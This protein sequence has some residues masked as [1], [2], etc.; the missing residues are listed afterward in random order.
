MSVKAMVEDQL[1]T[2]DVFSS[3]SQTS[4]VRSNFVIAAQ[5][6]H[7]STACLQIHAEEPA[8]QLENSAE[9]NTNVWAQEGRD[10]QTWNPCTI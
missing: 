3:K 2:G 8:T 9:Q 7:C 6:H 5:E 4:E 10:R 1:S